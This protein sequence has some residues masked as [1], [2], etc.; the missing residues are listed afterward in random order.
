[1]SSFK[2]N[3]AKIYVGWKTIR[4][5]R[6]LSKQT[7]DFPISAKEVKNVLV[8]LPVDEEYMDAALTLMRHLRQHFTHW[9]FMVLDVR[10]I[11]KEQKDRYELPSDQFINDLGK[12]EFKLVIDLNFESDLRMKLIIGMLGIPYRLHI[13]VVDSNDYNMFARINR[14]EFKG[15]NHVFNYLKSSFTV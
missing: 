1:M 10:K 7:V 5:F 12:N 3:V 4:T 11:P 9:H 14:E 13:Q 6:R 2:N 15:F 8:L